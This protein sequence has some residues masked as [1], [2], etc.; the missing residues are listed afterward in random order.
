[1]YVFGGKDIG[2]GHLNNLWSINLSDLDPFVVGESEYHPNSEWELI[3]TMGKDQPPPMSH[4]SSVEYNGKMYLFG[5]SSLNRENTD[6]YSLDL[7]RYQW[8]LV[9]SKGMNGDE[10]NIPYTRDEHS[11]V[12]Y[13]DSMIVF[14]GFAFGERTN[15]IFKF[16]FKRTW[17]EKVNVA[18]GSEIPCNRAGHSA[19]IRFNKELGDHMY[20]FGGK[21]DENLKL[22]D[23]WKFNLETCEWTCVKAHVEDSENSDELIPIARS[24]HASQVYNDCMIIYGGILEVTK[25]LNDMHIF[26]FKKEQWVTLFQE[27]NSPIKPRQDLSGMSPGSVGLRKS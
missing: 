2:I 7:N 4:H 17:W 27:L 13:N 1:L 24:G 12:I 10:S 19:V 11:C 20:I 23:V 6:M 3:E 16:D 5:G 18:K 8:N 21:N 14:G 22:N 9:K 25:E 26:D 15:S